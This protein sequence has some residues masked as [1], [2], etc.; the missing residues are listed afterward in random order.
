MDWQ[1]RFATVAD[2]P[3]LVALA[4]AFVAE[5][6]LPYE[7]DPAAASQTFRLFL[8]EPTTD[9]L[10]VEGPAAVVGFAVVGFETDFTVD[11]IGYLMKFYIAPGGR[12]TGAARALAWAA[13][14][15]FEAQNCVDAWATAT[16]G[17]G[18]D[19]VFVN[20]MGKVGFA[21]TG[22]TLRWVH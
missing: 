1:T 15:W 19:P 13:R 18:Q 6:T 16:A 7:F 12:G 14:A 11:P 9:V 21:P 2:V 20:L 5:T 3:A 17:V 22:P 8:D 4:A 10:V